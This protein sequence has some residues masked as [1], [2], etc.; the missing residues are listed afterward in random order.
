MA[1]RES[2]YLV[3]LPG[4]RRRADRFATDTDGASL[5]EFAFMF[6]ILLCVLFMTISLSHMM[7][8]DRK[9]T[10]TAQATAWY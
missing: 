4:L 6:P 10:R 7:M 8:I 2:R 9:V 1:D 5:V 3:A